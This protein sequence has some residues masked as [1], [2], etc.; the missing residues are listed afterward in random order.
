M[1]AVSSCAIVERDVNGNVLV[2]WSYPDLDADAEPVLRARSHLLSQSARRRKRGDDATEDDDA[3]DVAA[4]SGGIA[5]EVVESFSKFKQS[6][7][8]FVTVPLNNNTLTTEKPKL[9]PK[10]THVAVALMAET[11]HPEKYLALA[12]LLSTLY[13]TSGTPLSALQCFL[14]VFTK[15][16]WSDGTLSFK[17]SSFDIRHAYLASSLKS[18]INMLGEHV[19]LLWVA[20]I[21]KKRVGVF[22][23]DL[24]KLLHVIRGFPLLVWHRQSWNGNLWPYIAGHENEMADL[25]NSGFYTAGFTDP[26]AKNNTDMFDLIVDLDAESVTVPQHAKDSF[27]LSGFHKE[28]TNFL[29][30]SAAREDLTD[31]ALIKEL[32]RRTM[33]LI[34]KLETLKESSEENGSG[35]VTMESIHR[36]RVKPPMDQFMYALA[37]AEEIALAPESAEQQ[38]SDV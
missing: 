33:T 6:W 2:T 13:I 8:H 24:K 1:S 36:A 34:E 5:S 14:G 11:F 18:I 35:Y 19:I 20:L 10:V 4:N 16:D 31:Q 12:K 9:S 28:M 17:D 3:V 37:I 27:L 26:T 32:A 25:Q 15:G 22:C 7:V 21:I 29:V 23:Q 38:A 30:E